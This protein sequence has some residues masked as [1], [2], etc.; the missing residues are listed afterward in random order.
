MRFKRFNK[1]SLKLILYKLAYGP[2]FR[3]L[4]Y[5]KKVELIIYYVI[6][7]FKKILIL[8]N[9]CKPKLKNC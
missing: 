3:D 5:L 6:N 9:I 4:W 1:E 2:E 7:P 8:K